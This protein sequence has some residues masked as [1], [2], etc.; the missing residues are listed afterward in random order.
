MLKKK[1]TKD[2]K[3]YKKIK[4]LSRAATVFRL[5]FELLRDISNPSISKSG[6]VHCAAIVRM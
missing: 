6:S 1:Q 4:K 3:N 2:K 5:D